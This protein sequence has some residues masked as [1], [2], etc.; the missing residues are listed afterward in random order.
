MC[1]YHPTTKQHLFLLNFVSL[2]LFAALKKELADQQMNIF[3][4][5]CAVDRVSGKVLHLKEIEVCPWFCDE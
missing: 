3:N 4:G 1:I 2:Y 5:T